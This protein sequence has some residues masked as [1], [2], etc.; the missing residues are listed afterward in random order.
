MSRNT[1]TIKSFT[2][3]GGIDFSGGKTETGDNSLYYAENIIRENGKLR[4]RKGL[5]PANSTHIGHHDAMG[6]LLVPF[7]VT[8]M[9]YSYSNYKGKLAY[10]VWSDGLT[11]AYVNVYI[12]RDDLSPRFLGKVTVS[13][14]NNLFFPP[15]SVV[16][17]TGKP[18][19]GT[20]LFMIICCKPGTETY[21]LGSFNMYEFTGASLGFVHVPDSSYYV[22]I[23]YTNGR[24]NMFT[25]ARKNGWVYDETPQYPEDV[26]LLTGK[27]KA[28]FTSD[29]YSSGFKLPIW[30]LDDSMPAYCRIYENADSYVEWVL[31][32][33]GHSATI[34]YNGYQIT[35]KLD[36]ST[37]Y[38]RFTNSGAD[39][40]VP[41]SQKL[42]GNNLMITAHKYLPDCRKAVLS[43]K[44]ALMFEDKIYLYGNDFYKNEIYCC[45]SD[46]ILYFPESMKTTVGN[47]GDRVTALHAKG[48]SLFAFKKEGIFKISANEQIS[49]TDMILPIDVGRNYQITNRLKSAEVLQKLGCTSPKTIKNCGNKTVFLSDDKKV[50]S[51]SDNGSVYEISAPINKILA[52]ISI[53]DKERCFAAC[54]DHNYLLFIENRAFLL[55]FESGEFGLSESRGN[56]NEIKRVKWYHLCFPS[57]QLY[58]GATKVGENLYIICENADMR[59]AYVCMFS[60]QKDIV[61]FYTST[62]SQPV[63][64][65]IDFEIKTKAY[66]FGIPEV[67]KNIFSVDLLVSGKGIYKI[68]LDDGINTSNQNIS[69]KEESDVKIYPFM[70]PSY[71]FSAGISG[72]APFSLS[73]LSF[74][75][76]KK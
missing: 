67:K 29:G 27:F 33:S 11:F 5:I 61:P 16:F 62:S 65:D 72:R 56:Q 69:I 25:E 76:D 42:N 39:Y 9:S 55:D 41:R 2:L 60:G 68:G 40:A 66:D 43:S 24:G 57:S 1:K 46:N 38:L 7:T 54:F 34:N 20:G 59:E 28:F 31:P 13:R 45:A 15:K 17:M 4:T 30:Q 71:S 50:F 3:S 12:F 14:S 70:P 35:A 44:N 63:E 19:N 10:D 74:E 75:Y 64:S 22:P 52:D 18:V 73:K 8:D 6:R 49:K 32:A 21:S 51:V 36:C 47:F 48:K 26:N 58:T 23:I 53:T 37:G